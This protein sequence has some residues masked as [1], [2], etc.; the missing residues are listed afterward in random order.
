MQ[1]NPH[2]L[3]PRLRLSG[4]HHICPCYTSSRSRLFGCAP[5]SGGDST[6]TQQLA[7]RPDTLFPIVVVRRC[8][9]YHVAAFGVAAVGI[10]APGSPMTNRR[11]RVQCVHPQVRLCTAPLIPSLLQL[12]NS[13]EP[14][15][16]TSVCTVDRH[17]TCSRPC[18][19]T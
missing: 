5:P 1:G 13:S 12:I 9:R 11:I 14:Q 15:S 16:R 2:F 4:P 8:L 7:L 17:T 3:L 10:T 18:G 19:P 6:I